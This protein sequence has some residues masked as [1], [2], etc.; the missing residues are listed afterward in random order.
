M[1]T[2][3]IASYMDYNVFYD[4]KNHLVRYDLIKR[5]FDYIR[6]LGYGEQLVRVLSNCLEETEERRTT[7]EDLEEFLNPIAV[8]DQN[9]ILRS[10]FSENLN[11]N[12]V[13]HREIEVNH[14]APSLETASFNGD[15][16]TSSYPHEAIDNLPHD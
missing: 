15:K 1:T 11:I 8:Q 9:E 7:L 10:Q 16:N 12:S 4:Y 6:K 5:N 2:M 13:N 3:C 14:P